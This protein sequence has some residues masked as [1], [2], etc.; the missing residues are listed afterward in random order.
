MTTGIRTLSSILVLLAAAPLLSEQNTPPTQPA[1]TA[2]ATAPH[3]QTAEELF[4]RNIGTA[5]QQRKQ[6]PP[7]KIVGNIYYV[8]SESLGSFLVTTPEG[9]IL[10]NSCYEANVPGIKDSVEKLNF[11]FSDIK[12]LLG[13]HAHGDHMQGDAM[14]VDMTGAKAMA[15]AEDIDALKAM[16]SPAGKP[17][18]TYQTLHDGD[19]VKLG[20]TTLVAHL[21]PGHT[22]GCTTWTMQAQENGKTYDVA[23]IGSMGINSNTVSMWANG[24]LTPLGAEYTKGFQA[25]HAIHADVVLGS[26][27]AMYGLVERYAKLKPDGAVNPFIDPKAYEAELALEEGAF[28]LIIETQQKSSPTAPATAPV[29][30][31]PAL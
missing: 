20:G 12:I 4:R 5:A 6:F 30:T 28:K 19:P 26:H 3:I 1:S 2:P 27:P 13:S 22:H 23:I 14:I 29:A 7:H 9:H 10:I 17:R 25:M 8:G 11:K 15:M 16:G 21:T 31:R 24:A 18:P